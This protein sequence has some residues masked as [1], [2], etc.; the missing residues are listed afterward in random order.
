MMSILRFDVTDEA[1]FV[2]RAETA[3][4]VLAARPGYLRGRAGRSTDEPTRWVIVTE[5]R[6]VGSY[7]RA[8]GGYEVKLHAAPLLGESIDDPSAFE[9]LI[10]LRADDEQPIVRAS[11]RDQDATTGSRG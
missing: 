7:R 5:W 2:Q 10:E 1:G 3:L 6:D 9:E 8:L 11:D 4:R